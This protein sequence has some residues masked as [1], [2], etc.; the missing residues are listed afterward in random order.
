MLSKPARPGPPPP[1]TTSR[2]ATTTAPTGILPPVAAGPHGGAAAEGLD[3]LAQRRDFERPARDHHRDGAVL[4]ASRHRFEAG[5]ICAPDHLLRDRGGGD[6]EFADRL[7]EQ[8]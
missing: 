1:P 4:D 5:C 6:I 8:C 7:A 2:P 3:V